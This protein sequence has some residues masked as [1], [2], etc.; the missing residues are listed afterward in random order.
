MCR[1]TSL[2]IAL[3]ALSTGCANKQVATRE[4]ATHAALSTYPGN[5]Q[6]SDEV[7]LAAIDHPKDKRIDIVNLTDRAVATPTVWVNQSYVHKAATIKPRG[8]VTVKY[9]ELIEQG[10]GVRDL[11][12]AN[13]DVKTVEVQTSAGLFAVMGPSRK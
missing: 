9:S 3:L 2:L 12:M 8:Q 13:V 7:Q 1:N 5:P 4:Q 11:D 6:R 10:Q